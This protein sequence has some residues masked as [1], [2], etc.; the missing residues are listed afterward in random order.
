LPAAADE[1]ATA[2][3]VATPAATPVVAPEP[4]LPL[5][6]TAVADRT[7][8]ASPTDLRPSKLT[9]VSFAGRTVEDSVRPAVP[10][11]VP[12]AARAAPDRPKP[13]I[14]DMKLLRSTPP[15]VFDT[16]AIAAVKRWRYDPRRE[17]GV[18]VDYPAKVRLAF[19]LDE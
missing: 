11:P 3:P 8:V 19:R 10:A 1:P 18:P 13:V 15:G 16:E 2:A 7:P 12:P 4:G 6:A 17:D 14:M 5:P 9:A